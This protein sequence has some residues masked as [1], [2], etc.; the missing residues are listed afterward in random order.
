MMYWK[1][2]CWSKGFSF[3]GVCTASKMVEANVEAQRH[4]FLIVSMAFSDWAFMFL[5]ALQVA[6]ATER[7]WLQLG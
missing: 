4:R 1:A 2:L 3:P 6:Y 5:L 7:L